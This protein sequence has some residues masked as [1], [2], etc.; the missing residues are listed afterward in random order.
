MRGCQEWKGLGAHLRGEDHGGR[1]GSWARAGREKEDQGG[2]REGV[3]RC[4]S[5]IGNSCQR[6]R[7]SSELQ[8]TSRATGSTKER[9]ERHHQS[10]RQVPGRQ[11]VSSRCKNRRHDTSILFSPRRFPRALNIR[12]LWRPL[13]NERQIFYTLNILFCKGELPMG[14]GG[15]RGRSHALPAG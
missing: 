15:R 2:S 6:M 3:G 9:H 8:N 4:P 12:A 11:A 5:F 13:H 1:A 14:C 10:C 7:R